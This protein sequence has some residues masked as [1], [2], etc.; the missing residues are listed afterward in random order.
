MVV[1]RLSFSVVV[2]PGLSWCHLIGLGGLLPGV[3]QAVHK[4]LWGSGT[5]H[6]NLVAGCIES[7]LSG[8]HSVGQEERGVL[9]R[10]MERRVVREHHWSQVVLPIQGSFV[11]VKRQVLGD[12][13]VGHLSLAVTVGVVGCGGRACDLEQLEKIFC[14][15]GTEF[16]ALVNDDLQWNSKTTDPLFNRKLGSTLPSP[17]L[18]KGLS[19]SLH[20]RDF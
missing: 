12:H 15:F 10:A 13:F 17:C 7:W 2:F 11:Y 6:S 19:G 16:F 9:H 1:L 20:P 14:K 3:V 5:F 4:L 18:A 8:F